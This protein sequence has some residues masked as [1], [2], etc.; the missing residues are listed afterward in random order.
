MKN[1]FF[2]I[3]KNVPSWHKLVN[4]LYEL[5]YVLIDLKGIGGHSTR[6]PAEA[7]MIFIPNFNNKNGEKMIKENKDKFIMKIIW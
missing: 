4:H 2:S 6:L 3:Y 7:D 1:Y 5:D